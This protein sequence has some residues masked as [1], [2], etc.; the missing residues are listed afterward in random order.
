MTAGRPGCSFLFSSKEEQAYG[1]RA[2]TNP[3]RTIR[4]RRAAGRRERPDEEPIGHILKVKS[5]VHSCPIEFR[6]Q[7]HNRSTLGARVC[8]P[9]VLDQLPALFSADGRLTATLVDT[10][11]N[12]TVRQQT[13]KKTTI[14]K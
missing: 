9:V 12:R 13:T 14:K 6:R 11:G 2:R 5:P 8:W 4:R 10:V 7:A 1:S 3:H